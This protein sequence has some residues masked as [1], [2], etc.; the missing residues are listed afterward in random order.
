MRVIKLDYDGNVTEQ[1]VR[2][3]IEFAARVMRV[4]VKKVALITS[5]NGGMH[6]Y[7]YVPGGVTDVQAFLFRY[8]ANEDRKRINADVRRWKHGYPASYSYL[9]YAYINKPRQALPLPGEFELYIHVLAVA[10]E[11]YPL[12]GPERVHRRPV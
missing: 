2:E 5:R 6:A 3:W 7:V 8:Y 10:G 12:G 9:F 1:E 4:E 11:H